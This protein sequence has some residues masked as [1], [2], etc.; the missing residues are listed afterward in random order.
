MRH[1]SKYKF[2]IIISVLFI[3]FISLIFISKVIDIPHRILV[4]LAIF[5]VVGG[6]LLYL[7]SRWESQVRDAEDK[8]EQSR[9]LL[10]IILEGSPVAILLVKN[11]K[12]VWV[13]KSIEDILGWPVE[14]WLSEPSTVFS[15]PSKEEFDR[16]N[17]EII[18]KD[19]LRK[20]R[21]TYEYDY[22]HKNGHRVPTIIKIQALNKDNLGEGIIF[23]MI[24]NSDRIKTGEVIKKL[25]EGLEQKVRERTRE[26]AEKINELE[27]FKA[28]TVDR[29]LRMKEL[30]DEIAALKKKGKDKA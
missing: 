22:V 10:L 24:D 13:S 12:A 3:I 7:V 27:R 14:K 1:S 2:R 18:Y 5:I 4:E 16:V 11:N 29:E 19:I 23:S 20:G 25:N 17:N 30:I 28:V 15:Y 26:L 21:V 8:I 6:I 9:K